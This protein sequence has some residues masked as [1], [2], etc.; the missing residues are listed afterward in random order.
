MKPSYCQPRVTQRSGRLRRTSSAP[1]AS[2]P[3]ETASTKQVVECVLGELREWLTW[4]IDDPTTKTTCEVLR[5][6]SHWAKAKEVE[7]RDEPLHRCSKSCSP[8]LLEEQPASP[9][10]SVVQSTPRTHC[11][12]SPSSRLV[13]TGEESV[14]FLK[15]THRAIRVGLA[16]SVELLESGDAFLEEGAELLEQTSRLIDW[17]TRQ[18]DQ[19]FFPL[20]RAVEPVSP[21]SFSTH[22]SMPRL[23]EDSDVEHFAPSRPK[24]RWSL[25]S[26]LEH[27]HGTEQAQLRCALVA[28]FRRGGGDSADRQE[29]LVKLRQLATGYIQHMDQEEDTIAHG[30]RK[31]DVS[32]LLPLGSR[33]L[34]FEQRELL[35]HAI[36]FTVHQ[37]C[38][39][40]SY[41]DGLGAYARAIRS[42]QTDATWE[43]RSRFDRAMLISAW[44]AKPQ[45][46]ARLLQDALS[47]H[48]EQPQTRAPIS[49]HAWVEPVDTSTVSSAARWLDC[50]EIAKDPESTS[51]WGWR[52]ANFR[53]T[54]AELQALLGAE[55]LHEELAEQFAQPLQLKHVIIEEDTENKEIRLFFFIDGVWEIARRCHFAKQFTRR[56]KVRGQRMR[57]VV[58]DSKARRHLLRK[59]EGMSK[60]AE[61]D[62]GDREE[63]VD[64][65]DDD[66][67]RVLPKAEAA[68][69]P[70]QR[71]GGR[72]R[73]R[74]R[75]EGQA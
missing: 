22:G 27:D 7:V 48:P 61:D 43:S 19:V 57:V 55:Q 36:P 35:S 73:R 32:C 71:R 39:T 52:D 49:H 62:E 15:L 33:L 29:A 4:L 45:H 44:E 11:P 67:E 8:L 30:L 65:S 40:E 28:R 26:K 54:E 63:E 20:L 56:Y 75:G 14:V 41:N 38:R 25:F 6:V 9:L 31:A 18:E 69:A 23:A 13:P 58:I 34:E 10:S 12:T 68:A 17:H 60:A 74:G 59:D 5:A 16:Q 46:A 24:Q 66:L 3:A 47:S 50:A 37:L 21:Q 42:I 51:T 2:G 72:R 53:R 70:K 1:H 64:V